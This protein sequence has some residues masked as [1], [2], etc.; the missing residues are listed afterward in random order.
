MTAEVV[1]LRKAR[2]ARARGEAETRAA[3]N[4]VIFGRSKAEREAI[5]AE[6]ALRARRLDGHR[7]DDSTTPGPDDPA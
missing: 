4:R 7:R 1:N 2:K 3:E 6:D 5:A